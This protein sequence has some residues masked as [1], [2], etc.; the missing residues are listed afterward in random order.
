M[1]ACD[2]DCTMNMS[3]VLFF[4]KKVS[5]AYFTNIS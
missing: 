4:F 1:E 2:D 5:K 3:Y